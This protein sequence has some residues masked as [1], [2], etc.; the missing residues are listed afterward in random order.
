MSIKKYKQFINVSEDRSEFTDPDRES[1]DSLCK[2]YNIKNYTIR[3]DGAVDVDDGVNIQSKRLDILPLKFGE[4]TGN[5]TCGRNRLTSLEGSPHTV[6][7]HFSCGENQ[8]TSLVGGP[9]S[10]GGDFY[11]YK[12]DLKSFEGFPELYRKGLF[13][14]CKDNPVH[15]VYHLFDKSDAITLM[16]EW[17]V[18][19]PDTMEV[20]FLRLCEVYEG[21]ELEV[22][23]RETIKFNQ[24]TL[25][26]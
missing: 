25:I 11:C 14:D 8:L 17:D 20:S 18:I 22:P 12:N 5:F 21:L 19:N 9:S 1:I 4:V 7:G 6:G 23:D 3:E 15:E 26:D 13:L 2:E 10:V 24:Y 16:N